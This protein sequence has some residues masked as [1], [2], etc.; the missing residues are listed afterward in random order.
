[1]NFP[2]YNR[3]VFEDIS[4]LKP[5]MFDKEYSE[6]Y[7][8]SDIYETFVAY[9]I[10]THFSVE[11]FTASRIEVIQYSFDEELT[12]LDAVH[13]NYILK[14]ENSLY[15]YETSIKKELPETVGFDGCIQI[16]HGDD[17]DYEYDYNYGQ[18]TSYFLA[19]L[20]INDEIYVFQMTG[21][22]ENMGYLY[23]DFLKILS[24]IES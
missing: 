8:I 20:N 22:K 11:L 21:K 16:I 15:N 17:T 18:T 5:D 7:I 19:T 1:M 14:R 23:D 13:D 6:S 9:E 12:E 2:D 3:F 4:F 10:F 24:S